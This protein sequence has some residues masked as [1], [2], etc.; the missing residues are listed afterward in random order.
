[1]LTDGYKSGGQLVKHAVRTA[2][3][4]MIASP[5][6]RLRLYHYEIR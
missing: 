3:N 5:N 2:D 1:M 4:D 6:R